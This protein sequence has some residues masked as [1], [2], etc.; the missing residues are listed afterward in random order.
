MKKYRKAGLLICTL[1]IPALIF[2]FLNF[3]AT[4]HY[5]I[6]FYHPL[7]NAD[8]TVKVLKDD[9]LFYSVGGFAARLQNGSSLPPHPFKEKLTVINYVSEACDDSCQSMQNNL[10]RIYSLRS[11][12]PLLQLVT[13]CD[14]ITDD[15]KLTPAFANRNGWLLAKVKPEDLETIQNQVLKFDTRIPKA[16]NNSV[17]SKLI[18]IDK[19]ETIRGYYNGYDPEEINRLMAEI[20]ILDF[21]KGVNA[22]N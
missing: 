7:T 18:F 6:P 15:I 13:V 1:V 22:P 3:F 11:Q 9:T 4:N 14:S 21:E 16:K 8:G 12:I 5:T 17:Q 10:E 2:T 19:N 20:K